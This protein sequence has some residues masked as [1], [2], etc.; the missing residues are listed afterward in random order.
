MGNSYSN[1]KACVH[2]AAIPFVGLS[3]GAIH[4]LRHAFNEQ[5]EGFGVTKSK[6]VDMASI[7]SEQMAASENLDLE[8]KRLKRSTKLYFKLLDTDHNKLVD[9][10][11]CLSGLALISSMR[12]IEKLIFILEL[13]DFAHLN[14]LTSDECA[15]AMIT[16]CGAVAVITS[17]KP[18]PSNVIESIAWRCFEHE[19]MDPR[20][21]TDMDVIPILSMA[22]HIIANNDAMAYVSHFDNILGSQNVKRDD[23]ISSIKVGP[24]LKDEK[25]LTWF[26]AD[27]EDQLLNGINDGHNNN[28]NNDDDDDEGDDGIQVTLERL[29]EL[30]AEGMNAGMY[31]FIIEV[32]VIL[33]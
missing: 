7:L 32:S 24:K 6:L 3:S 17:T 30:H 9:A 26:H 8:A 5:L 10:I 27:K 33:K 18:P 14:K 16:G 28:N 29:K 13:F 19:G 31:M 2:K 25:Q 11:G 1:G 22:K 4:G 20:P 15:M 23:E 21:N 12:I